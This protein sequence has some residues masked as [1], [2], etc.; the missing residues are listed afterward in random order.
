MSLDVRRAMTALVHARED[1]QPTLAGRMEATMETFLWLV[2]W[3]MQPPIDCHGHIAFEDC[4]DRDALWHGGMGH[5]PCER[6]QPQA[7]Q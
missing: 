4:A 2:G 6:A 5:A 3:N 7:F 1:G